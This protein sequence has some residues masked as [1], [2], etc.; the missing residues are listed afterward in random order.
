MSS[1]KYSKDQKGKFA[2]VCRKS[3][4]N[5]AETLDKGWIDLT[6]KD[7][8]NMGDVYNDWSRLRA[9]TIYYLKRLSEQQEDDLFLDPD[10][11][12]T[13]LSIKRALPEV[14]DDI[15]DDTIPPNSIEKND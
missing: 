14:Y 2:D 7:G 12:E 10:I 11:H 4:V 13:V 5:L 6:E 8:I 15:D 1:S 3:A 9:F